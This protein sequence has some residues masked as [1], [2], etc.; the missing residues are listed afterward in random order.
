M[1]APHTR[2][3][4]NRPCEDTSFGSDSL[5]RLAQVD[6]LLHTHIKME[7]E[8]AFQREVMVVSVESVIVYHLCQLHN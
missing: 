1:T 4:L 6:G 7:V 2:G 8:R 5:M 3:E